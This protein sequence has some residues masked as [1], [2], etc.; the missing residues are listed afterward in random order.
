MLTITATYTDK[1]G[2][3]IKPLTATEALSLHNPKITFGRRGGERILSTDSI[4]LAEIRSF[5]ISLTPGKDTTGSR[6]L[7]IHLDAESGATIGHLDLDAAAKTPG[8]FSATL[9]PV[10]DG[11]PHRLVITRSPDAADMRIHWLLLK[12]K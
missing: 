5:D 9:D 11:Q 12:D 1:G 7:E 4:D 3:G 8:I 6:R 10:T 2:P